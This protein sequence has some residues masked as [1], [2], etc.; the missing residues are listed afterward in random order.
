MV[1]LCLSMLSSILN[2]FRFFP[3]NQSL[4]LASYCVSHNIPFVFTIVS[5]ISLVRPQTTRQIEDLLSENWREVD[6]CEGKWEM[7]N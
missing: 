5:R 6:N 1:T 2:R 7:G 4:L 3:P